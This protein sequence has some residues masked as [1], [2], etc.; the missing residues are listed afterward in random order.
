VDERQWDQALEYLDSLARLSPEDGD[1]QR[2]I[3]LILMEKKLWPEAETALLQALRMTPTKASL[4]Y[5]LGLVYE[6]QQ[7]WDEADITLAEIPASDRLYPDALFHRAFLAQ[8]RDDAHNAIQLLEKRLTFGQKSA[9]H[10]DFLASLWEQIKDPLAALNALDRGL[11]EFPLDTELL[12]HRGMLLD[13]Q[14]EREQALA[15]M[16]MILQLNADHTEALN[17]LAYFLAEQDRELDLAL[18]MVTRAMQQEPKPHIL[19]TYAWV[20]YRL[21]RLEDARLKLEEV[22]QTLIEDAVVWQHLGDVY[23]DLGRLED[24]RNAYEQALQQDPENAAELKSRLRQLDPV[25]E[26]ADPHD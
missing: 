24:A 13:R 1:I 8:Q 21:G 26:S 5:Y 25:S 15:T 11:E 10:F 22:V 23:R 12:Y 17:F 9:D 14:G 16:R 3:G 7:R 4:H 18:E 2:R 20:L 19:D 6:Q